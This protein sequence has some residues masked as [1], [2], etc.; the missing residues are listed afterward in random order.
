MPCVIV[1]MNARVSHFSP[2]FPPPSSHPP[3]NTPQTHLLL[4]IEFHLD[5]RAAV[6]QIRH[7]CC[8]GGLLGDWRCWVL[9]RPQSSHTPYPNTLI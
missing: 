7:L 3:N 8:F 1:C 6:E 5:K 9:G 2:F 4:L